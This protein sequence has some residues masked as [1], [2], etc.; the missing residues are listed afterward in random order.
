MKRN[1][2]R[3]HHN[4]GLDRIL[5]EL[6]RYSCCNKCCSSVILL[7]NRSRWYAQKNIIVTIWYCVVAVIIGLGDGPAPVR[8]DEYYI[9]SYTILSNKYLLWLRAESDG[10]CKAAWNNMV[11]YITRIH[12]SRSTSHPCAKVM[13]HMKSLCYVAHD[14]YPDMKMYLKYSSQLAR[15]VLTPTVFTLQVNEHH[16]YYICH[17]LAC[18]IVT[19]QIAFSPLKSILVFEYQYCQGAAWLFSIKWVYPKYP[20]FS[21]QWHNLIWN[22]S[23]KLF[24]SMQIYLW[25]NLYKVMITNGLSNGP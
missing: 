23:W 22:M 7:H 24:N 10:V 17:R 5:I 6:T 25:G 1:A 15:F 8:L 12:R 19:T 20:F 21:S 4:N 13:G 9:Y 14:I 3:N 18:L 2:I 11:K 16:I